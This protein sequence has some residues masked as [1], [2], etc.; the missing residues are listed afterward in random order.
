MI[1]QTGKVTFV[2]AGCG[3]PRLLTIRA[4]EVLGE[5][6]FVLFDP[7]VH[8]DVLARLREGTP[9][10][11]IPSS[12]TAERIGTMLADE[13]KQGRRAVRLAWADPLLFGWGDAEGSSVARHGVPIEIVP[14]IG[15]FIAVGAFAG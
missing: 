8:P 13:A 3:D 15:P 7:E 12:M 10:H 11:P 2:G 5:A 4:V 14:G 9:R 1:A 6:D